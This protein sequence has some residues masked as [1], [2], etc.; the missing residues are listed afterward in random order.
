MGDM[1]S[2]KTTQI[3]QFLLDA[4]LAGKRC[5]RGEAGWYNG[6]C[7]LHRQQETREARGGRMRDG[8]GGV[9]LSL[10]KVADA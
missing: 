4:G 5:V 9:A 3:P 6:T 2:S 7:G 8:F 10:R 1:G